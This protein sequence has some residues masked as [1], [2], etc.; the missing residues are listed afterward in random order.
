MAAEAALAAS[1]TLL[2]YSITP[3]TA[4]YGATGVTFT[5]T[6]LNNGSQDITFNPGDTITLSM[7]V[8]SGGTDLLVNSSVTPVSLAFGFQFVQVSGQ[9]GLFL[10]GALS[11]QTIAS[12]MALAFQVI[13]AQINTASTKGL[14]PTPIS[15]PVNET[16]GTSGNTSYVVVT[17]TLPALAVS[18]TASPTIVG[19]NQPTS[20]SWT[21]TS[22]NYVILMPGNLRQ[23]CSGI[24][25]QGI[26]SN[27]VPAQVPVTPFQVTAYTDDGQQQPSFPVNVQTVPPTIDF[28]PQNL[29][30]IGYQDTVTLQ[31]TTQYANT[32]Y[33]SP[34]QPP[35]VGPSGSMTIKPSKY[36]LPNA[37]S[38]VFTL[39][40]YGYLG[41]VNKTVTINFLPVQILSFGYPV[42]PPTDQQ[43]VAVVQNGL[44]QILQ[45]GTNP[46][47]YQLTA[48]GAG[49]P[50]TRFLGPGPWLEIMY[51]AG[52]PNPVASGATCTLSWVTQNA[53]SATLNGSPVTLNQGANNQQTGSTAVSPTVSTVYTLAV[54]DAS[55]NTMASQ[56][57]VAVSA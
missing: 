6:A 30:P 39:T 32:V 9:P 38:V 33:L 42:P 25:S 56:I 14:Q 3:T 11:Q 21:A 17:K 10:V 49:G 55:G 53:V 2:N 22:A 40:A 13:G 23:N 51:F 12:G 44:Q 34:M 57:T 4:T 54:T 20:I 1:N 27:V 16:I 41:A 45:T 7:P 29:P 48:T 8:G 28:G 5:L 31:W 50:L 37:N 26:F 24:L 15:M 52:T 19:L 43:P 47:T 35:Q 36:A 46:N 18:C